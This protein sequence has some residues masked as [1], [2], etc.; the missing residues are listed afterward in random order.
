MRLLANQETYLTKE[1]FS[2]KTF[3]SSTVCNFILTTNARERDL[4]RT[5]HTV[6][7][8]IFDIVVRTHHIH[9]PEHCI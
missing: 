2:R 8:C 4:R 9:V 5:S 1:L 3:L 6:N 7:P